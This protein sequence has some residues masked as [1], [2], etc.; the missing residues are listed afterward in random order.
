MMRARAMVLSIISPMLPPSRSRWWRRRSSDRRGAAGSGCSFPARAGRGGGTAVRRANG[1]QIRVQQDARKSSLCTA[2]SSSAREACMSCRGSTARPAKRPGCSGDA[3]Q[4]VV[5][6][7]GGLGTVGAESS[8]P[9]SLMLRVVVWICA[10]FMS[11][12]LASTSVC[13]GRTRR[14][15][16]RLDEAVVAFAIDAR[17]RVPL[18]HQRQQF[19]A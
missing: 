14:P 16:C 4:K 2:R 3:G 17:G 9:G 10:A 19:R 8:G 18:L 6:Q 11:A 12:S 7:P 15:I 13:L 1:R 5:R